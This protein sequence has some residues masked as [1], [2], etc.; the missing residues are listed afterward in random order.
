MIE[1]NV[2]YWWLQAMTKRQR[3]LGISLSIYYLSRLVFVRH[4]F[5]VQL[6][7]R[8][9][10]DLVTDLFDGI[11][12]VLVD[13]LYFADGFFESFTRVLNCRRGVVG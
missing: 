7:L 12:K 1:D 8:V 13:V 9:L 6:P 3:F 5:D 2:E 10:F 11:F 4:L